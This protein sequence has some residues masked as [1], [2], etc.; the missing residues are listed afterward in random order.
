MSDKIYRPSEEFTA[1]AHIDGAGYDAM[2]A[3]SVSDP[4][5]FWGAHGKRIDW[6][7][8]YSIVKNTSFVPG[9]IDIKWFEDGTLN[10]CANCVDRHLPARAAQTAI[11]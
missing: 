6:I 7:T 3:A 1:S 11:I 4:A 8:P 5:A 10:A 9:Q 2:Y